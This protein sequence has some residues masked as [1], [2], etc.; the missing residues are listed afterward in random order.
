MRTNPTTNQARGTPR[1]PNGKVDGHAPPT[2]R[3]AGSAGT[4]DGGHR[5]SRLAAA[6]SP[7]VAIA[8]CTGSSRTRPAANERPQRRAGR[9]IGARGLRGFPG[10]CR[11]RSRRRIAPVRCCG[12]RL[13]A[14]LAVL[15]V[16]GSRPFLRGLR[17]PST[18]VSHPRA[19]GLEIPDVVIRRGGH[20]RCS[21][22][23]SS[24]AGEVRVGTRSPNSANK[25][26][27]PAGATVHSGRAAAS[28]VLRTAW[29]RWPGCLLN[30]RPPIALVG[31]RAD[32]PLS[33]SPTPGSIPRSCD[34]AAEA[35][36]PAA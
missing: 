1:R 27:R 22:S 20:D 31:G 26:S 24:G 21:T 33:S 25:R 3:H 8:S 15:G 28:V 11:R 4:F 29:R 23:L 5:K 2:L 9:V 14:A 6:G 10:C 16:I 18:D 7:G 36:H 34:G 30:P 19:L 32:A 35:R 13:F 17:P 12:T